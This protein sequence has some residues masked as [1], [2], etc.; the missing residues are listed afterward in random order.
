MGSLSIYLTDD[1]KRNIVDE[2]EKMMEI[3]IEQEKKKVDVL[4]KAIKVLMN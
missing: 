2:K 1:N 3:H 4:K